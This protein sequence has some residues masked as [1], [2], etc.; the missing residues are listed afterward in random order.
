MLAQLLVL[1]KSYK[2]TYELNFKARNLGAGKLG[3]H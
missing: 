3:E 2:N 1:P